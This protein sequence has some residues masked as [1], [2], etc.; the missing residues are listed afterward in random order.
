MDDGAR[1]AESLKRQL[2]MRAGAAASLIVL[3][4]AGLAVYERMTRVTP[5]PPLQA[6]PPPQAP[7]AAEAAS[8]GG[9][10]V[11]VPPENPLADAILKRDTPPEPEM[12][13]APEVAPP[14]QRKAD[15]PESPRGAPRLVLGGDEPVAA[16]ASRPAHSPAVAVAPAARGEGVSPGPAVSVPAE[17]ALPA[18]KGY[19]VQLGVFESTESAEALRSRLAGLGIPAR[20]E[21]RVVV[22]PFS[23]KSAAREAQAQLREAGQSP[24]LILPPRR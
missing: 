19:L 1:D 7:A 21:S 23:T 16:P 11:A 9:S 5:A 13:S 15:A 3:L 2:M 24:G 8:G 6:I 17:S 10:I 14:G 20:L 18:G 4:L 12:A 22:G